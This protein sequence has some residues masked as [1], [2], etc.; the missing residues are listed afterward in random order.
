MSPYWPA[1]AAYNLSAAWIPYNKNKSRMWF[2]RAES[3]RKS[4][5][6]AFWAV[7]IGLCFISAVG[8]RELELALFF[9]RL[10]FKEKWKST[11][12]KKQDLKKQWTAHL[13]LTIGLANSCFAPEEN[14]TAAIEIFDLATKAVENAIE[15]SNERKYWRF[16]IQKSR[17]YFRYRH[18]I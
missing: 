8:F 10:L 14:P 9:A 18:S 2:R 5:K 15:D 16:E 1:M 4:D 7:R 17:H 13:G 6:Q 3:M 11:T 12:E